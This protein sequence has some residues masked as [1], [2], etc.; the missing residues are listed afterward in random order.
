MTDHPVAVAMDALKAE[1]PRITDAMK[2]FCA[3]LAATD[4]VPEGADATAKK[5]HDM[6]HLLAMAK[7]VLKEINAHEL[8]S[9]NSSPH[10]SLRMKS[11]TVC[12]LSEL[13]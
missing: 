6:A 5:P 13:A 12:T 11:L 1:M 3:Y 7:V 10:A 2:N 8:P 9:P 4:L